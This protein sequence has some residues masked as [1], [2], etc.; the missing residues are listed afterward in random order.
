[1]NIQMKEIDFYQILKSVLMVVVIVAVLIGTHLGLEWGNSLYPSRSITVSAEGKTTVSP[2]IAKLSFSVISEGGN[3]AALETDNAKK[4]T[5]AVDYVKSQGVDDK[6]IRTSSYDLSPKYVYND[7]TRKSY[8][9]G[10]TMTQTTSVKVRDLNKV[11]DILG[12]L[13]ERGVNQIGSVTFTVD[14]PDKYLDQARADA[15][16]KAAAKAK[17]MAEVNRVRIVRVTNFYESQGGPIPYYDTYS[18]GGGALGMGTSVA[19]SISAGSSDL[20]VQVSVTY[21]IE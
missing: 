12:G 3:P 5:A 6:D 1:M 7:T 13:S 14:D 2:D 21:E 20:T 19:P 16:N 11:A 8:I 4:V 9:D 18:K 17:L 15:F 10:Y